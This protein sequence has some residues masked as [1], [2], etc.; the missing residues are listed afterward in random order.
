LA[1]TSLRM[2]RTHT[3]TLRIKIVAQM[4][5]GQ[6]EAA[7][8]TAQTLL[9]LQPGLTVSTWLKNSPTREFTFGEEIAGDLKKAGIPQ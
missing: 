8:N 4:R 1:E 7:R 9:D 3:S 2:N 5:L 6:A